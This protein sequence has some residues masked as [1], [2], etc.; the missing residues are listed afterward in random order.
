MLIVNIWLI[1]IGF[2]ISLLLP[3][4]SFISMIGIIGVL[5][6]A[7]LMIVA[8]A[9][10]KKFELLTCPGCGE[11][12]FFDDTNYSDHVTYKVTDKNFTVSA[13]RTS[14]DK[15][16][17]VRARGKEKTTAYITCKCSKCSAEKSFGYA[18]DTF[19]C[20]REETVS[21]REAL[22]AEELFSTSIQDLYNAGIDD[23]EESVTDRFSVS[24]HVKNIKISRKRNIE[25]A[26]HGYF[27]KNELTGTIIK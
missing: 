20:E 24:V 6:S 12:M 7:F 3:F 22:Q 5:F 1:V 9:A 13:T 17:K 19:I 8:S 25:T 27:V 14:T 10:K 21:A 4:L 23:I 18:Y 11:I 16:V 2:L 26:I 15:G